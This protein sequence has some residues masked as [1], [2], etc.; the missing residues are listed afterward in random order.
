MTEEKKKD[1]HKMLNLQSTSTGYQGNYTATVSIDR[2]PDE[3]VVR[4]SRGKKGV[5][6]TET[7]SKSTEGGVVLREQCK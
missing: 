3:K 7:T 2:L 5:A 1:E 4:G 6:E